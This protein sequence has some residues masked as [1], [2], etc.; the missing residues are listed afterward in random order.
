MKKND[1]IKIKIT[2]MGTGGE[3]IGKAD[4]FT[5]FVK[6]AVIEDEVLA[7]I[8]KMN[9]G[10][11]F[12]KALEILKPSRFRTEPLCPEAKRCG[13]CQIMELSYEKQLQFKENKVR[14]NLERIGGFS[15]SILDKVMNPIVGMEN[16]FNYR[17]KAQ[18]PIGTDKEGKIITGFYA[19]RTHQII[20]NNDC[21]LGVKYNKKILETII[22]FMEENHVS[23]YDEK[24][25]KGLVRHVLLRYGFSSKEILVCL[26]IN[27]KKLP[28][29]EKLVEALRALKWDEE[30][31]P[32]PEI[33]SISININT[34]KNNVILGQETKLL[35]G[36][37]YITDKIGDVNFR[38]SPQSFFQVNPV[39]TEKMYSL[40]LSYAG[41]T[42]KE[43]VWDLYCGIGTISLFLAKKAKKVY[44]IE[45]VPQAISDAKENAKINGITNAE[46]FVG[47]AE[48]ILPEIKRSAE[49]SDEDKEK[50]NPDVIVVDP[51]RK[52]CDKKLLDTILEMSPKRVV[53]V[54]CDS[55]T[56]SRDLKILCES[57]YELKE[58]TPVDNFCQTVHVESVVL[59]SKTE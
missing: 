11:G 6:G 1:K 45:I 33:K 9:K 3:G 56:L 18:Y 25:G 37:P 59:L 44:G 14:N 50:K 22:K 19:G 21:A 29:S 17:N 52:G 4:D 27:G 12:A 43:T 42:G 20:S 8:T 5:F 40:A 36:S 47:K 32:I 58:V 31:G 13:G 41:L 24:E 46:F 53:Y 55:A 51:P 10:Y 35:W 48:E 54:S 7:V 34:Q 23:A 16:P 15:E 26:I 38:I 28:A 49:N 57:N 39:Q 30:N 2:D